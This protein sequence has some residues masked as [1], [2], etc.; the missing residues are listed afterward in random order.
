VVIQKGYNQGQRPIYPEDK[1]S[2]VRVLLN[3][4]GVIGKRIAD[5]VSAQDDMELAGV[6]DVVSDWRIKVAVEKGYAVIAST[7]EAAEAMQAAGLNVQGTLQDML[8]QV[9]VVATAHPKA[10]A[11]RTWSITESEVLKPSFRVERSTV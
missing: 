4:Y 2:K 8:D 6:A 11:P 7:Q 10:S 5:A 1:M 3:G 9:D